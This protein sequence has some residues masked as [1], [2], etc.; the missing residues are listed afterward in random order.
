MSCKTMLLKIQHGFTL[1]ELLITMAVM[2]VLMAIAIPNLQ[3]FVVSNQLSSDVNGFVGLVNYARSEAIARNQDVV[4]CPKTSGAITC[5][6]NQFWGEYEIQAFVDING[7]GQRNATDIL[8]K[9][10][11]ATDVTANIRRFTRVGGVGVIRFSAVGLSQTAH[12]F[13]TFA[14]KAGDPEYES[15]YG[16][17]ICISR[18]GRARV[19]P[20]AAGVAACDDF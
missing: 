17:S 4:I 18:P 14:I 10:L 8:L 15:R 5:E 3:A 13:D 7:N 11:P 1:I 6:N 9:T 12:R 16:R 20:L 2:G 19:T